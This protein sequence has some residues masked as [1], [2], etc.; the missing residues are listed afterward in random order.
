M[1]IYE[2]HCR[3]CG[4]DFEK[5]VRRA[6]DAD[7]V[8]CPQCSCDEAERRMSVFGISGMSQA[9]SAPAA[10]CAPAGGG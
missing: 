8:G 9:Q 10:G 2:Y 5:L 1:P 6:E 4:N 7:S 3:R